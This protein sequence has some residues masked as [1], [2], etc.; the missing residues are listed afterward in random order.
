M[1]K[2]AKLVNKIRRWHMDKKLIIFDKDGT[3]LDFD[4]YWIPVSEAAL[5]DMVKVARVSEAA[6]PEIFD[7]F[8]VK[9]GVTSIKSSLSY[10][11]YDDM[12]ADIFSVLKKYGAQL[13]ES[14]VKRL[15]RKLYH[16]HIEKGE[17]KPTSDALLKT[18]K[19]LREKGFTLGVVTSDAPLVTEE[20]LKALGIRDYFSFV[21]TDDGVTP[22]K[23]CPDSLNKICRELAISHGDVFMVGDTLTDLAYAKAAGVEAIGLAK[24]AEN[25]DILKEGGADYVIKDILEI[26]DILK[27]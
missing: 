17:I 19:T 10:G 4:A 26:L 1:L 2:Y 3:L 22:T 7:A 24:S 23:P 8:M 9:D 12:G 5:Y 20:C 18:L 27:L 13:S 11:T 21:I 25:A 16:D 14:E 15:T 6:I